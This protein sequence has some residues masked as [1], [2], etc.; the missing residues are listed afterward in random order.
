MRF[1]D[2]CVTS[3]ALTSFLSVDPFIQEP[4]NTQSINPYSYGMN[5]PLAGTD[6]TG[7]VFFLIPVAF[8]IASG[9]VA[10]YGAWEAGQTIG[11]AVN[12]ISNGKGDVQDILVNAATEIAVDKA[13]S[14]VK[15][16]K[17]AEKVAPKVVVDKVKDVAEK[18]TGNKPDNGNSNNDNKKNDAAD[19]EKIGEQNKNSVDDQS[20]KAEIKDDNSKVKKRPGSFR[21][22]TL[23]DS[24]DNAV[25]GSKSGTKKCPTCDKDVSGNPHKNEKRNKPN[26]WDNDHQPKWKDRDLSNMTR[27]QVLDEYNKDTQLRCP[28]CN[29]SDN[30]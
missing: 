13:M 22:K 12:D 16:L 24:W 5:N 17:L 28:S 23:K 14:A 27:K 3:V 11:N 26:G 25:N 2:D 1:R 30:Q 8:E 4:G 7:Y 19:K 18:V 6:P 20:G 21:K 29:R 10:L 9:A 15:V